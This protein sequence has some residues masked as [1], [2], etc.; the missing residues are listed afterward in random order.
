[1]PQ[2]KEPCHVEITQEAISKAGTGLFV[3]KARKDEIRR[4]LES[5]I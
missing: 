5:K 3:D 1:M 4:Y 2:K